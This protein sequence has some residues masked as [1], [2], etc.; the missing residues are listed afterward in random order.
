M[1]RLKSYVEAGDIECGYDRC[2]H[3]KYEP[4]EEALKTI[5]KA[6]SMENIPSV[7]RNK[8]HGLLRKYFCYI[9][10]QEARELTHESIIGFILYIADKNPGSLEPTIRAMRILMNYLVEQGEHQDIPDLKFIVPPKR[11]ES[12]YP[13]FTAAEISQI[14]DSIDR[15]T[16]SGK[17]N[18]AIVLLAISTGFRAKDIIRIKLSNIDWKQQMINIIQ[19]KTQKSVTMPISGQALN[20][21]S[22]YILNGRPQT[23]DNT[24]FV[25]LKAPF[26]AL[27]AG[28]VLTT[29]F[30]R[31]CEKARI[32][33]LQGRCFHSLR[34]TFGTWLANEQ[35]PIITISQLLG[36]TNLD[37]S[38]PYL[39]FDDKHLQ[40][41][42][43][44]LSGI[45]IDRRVFDHELYGMS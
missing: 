13:A 15:T 36:H 4:S 32:K 5:E 18:Y 45:P 23:T 3:R 35:I 22:D 41:C 40:Q 28:P 34:R 42:A 43:M 19:S 30:E 20:A 39:S 38:K 31:Q 9:E 11:Q 21:L 7:F 1:E 17:R 26:I 24:V 25:R 27:S 2:S 6:L 16:T 10:K 14:L 33:K 12:I 37:S 29:M 44:D 8:L